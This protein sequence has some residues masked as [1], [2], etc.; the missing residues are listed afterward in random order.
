MPLERPIRIRNADLTFEPWANG[1]GLTSPIAADRDDTR[2][3]PRWRLS[4][5]QLSGDSVFSSFAGTDR[6]FTVVGEHGVELGFDDERRRCEPGSPVSFRGEL[7]PSCV[8]TRPTRAFNVMVERGGA[9][10]KV[11]QRRVSREES[12]QLDATGTR[13][14]TAV[15]LISGS[16]RIDSI[17]MS[18]GDTLIAD[19]GSALLHGSGD[20]LIVTIGTT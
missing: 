4:L 7:T 14:V 9:T 13:L 6:V 1:Q 2:E 5:A 3:L 17:E 19:E 15:F 11:L 18:P 10:A 16:A 8:V 20:I 12:I